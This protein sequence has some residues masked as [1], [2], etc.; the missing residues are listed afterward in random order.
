MKED[1]W[2]D[3]WKRGETAFHQDEINPYLSQYWP[4]LGLVPGSMVFVPLC[5]KSR[6][7]L[8]LRAQGHPI[9]GIELSNVAAEAFFVENGLAPKRIRSE[10]FDC[11]E[12]DGIRILCGD[13]FDLDKAELASVHA[14]YDRGALIALPP[15]T[16][17]RYAAHLLGI[18]PALPVQPASPTVLPASAVSSSIQMLLITLD[19]PAG[20]MEGPPFAVPP[21]EVEALYKNKKSKAHADIRLLLHEDVLEE[22]P[23][24]QERGLSRL[25]ENIFLLRF[26]AGGR[27]GP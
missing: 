20:E 2:L 15:E 18:L 6:D 13:F 27:P 5:G 14:I 3:R 11:Y 4:E 24:F 16:R 8:W 12:A 25:A 22:N 17:K 19:Y 10:K 7:M 1:Y 23:R 9:L 21:E 26:E